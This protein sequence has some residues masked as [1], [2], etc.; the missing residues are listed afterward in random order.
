MKRR[1]GFLSCFELTNLTWRLAGAL[2]TKWHA[3]NGYLSFR[4]T[5]RADCHGDFNCRPSLFV[6]WKAL[7]VNILLDLNSSNSND[8]GA[9]IRVYAPR[10]SSEFIGPKRVSTTGSADPVE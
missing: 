5:K 2:P 8:I 7:N 4:L 3:T 9:G 6:L 1:A 10:C